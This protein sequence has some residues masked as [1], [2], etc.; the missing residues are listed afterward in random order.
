MPERGRDIVP[1]TAG[2]TVNSDAVRSYEAGYQAG[3][4]E[5]ETEEEIY[6]ETVLR[7]RED[8]EVDGQA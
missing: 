3:L 8:G 7:D 2:K 1:R 4:R 5:A 6:A